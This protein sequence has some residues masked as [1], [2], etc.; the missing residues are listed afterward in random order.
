[1]RIFV[2]IALTYIFWSAFWGLA[3]ENLTPGT[4]TLMVFPPYGMSVAAYFYKFTA[5]P[6]VAAIFFA[7]FT[8]RHF[9]GAPNKVQLPLIANLAFLVAFVVV[10][11]IQL[12]ALIYVQL[13][14]LEPD[15]T[16]TTS[17]IKSLTS[18]EATPGHTTAFKGGKVYQ[19]S[20]RKSAFYLNEKAQ[21]PELRLSIC[22]R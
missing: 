9:R 17:F 2:A 8:V 1:M 10:S 16:S 14:E 18:L 3:L 5:L 21:Q 4:L 20:F 22:Q 7:G 19:W 12:S 6:I 15:C 11:Q 13:A